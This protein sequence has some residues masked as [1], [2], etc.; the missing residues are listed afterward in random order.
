MC[1]ASPVNPPRSRRWGFFVY[2]SVKTLMAKNI[3]SN[4]IR[5]IDKGQQGFSSRLY[6]QLMRSRRHL[7][8][9]D[10]PETLGKRIARLR[11]TKG[12]TQIELAERLKISQSNVSEYERDNLR[13]HADI[14][15][16][17]TKILEV[18]ADE[19][20]GITPKK[21]TTVVHD[22]RLARRLA[23]IDQLPKRDKDA[24]VRTISA[25]LERSS[26]AA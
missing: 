21:H 17:L 23:Q 24:L 1:W 16:E 22:V 19:L 11:K 14:I 15:V 20:L 25:F 10:Q 3:G 5:S 4:N 13:L 18:S 12:I 9:H 2:E 6:T 7:H 8:K 26:H